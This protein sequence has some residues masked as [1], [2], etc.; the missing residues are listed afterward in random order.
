LEATASSFS[1]AR[2]EFEAAWNDPANTPFELPPVDVN[3]VLRERYSLGTPFRMTREML[4]DMEAKKAWDPLSFIPYVVSEG[5]SW[6]RQSLADGSEHFF[7]ASQ[8]AAWIA[9]GRGL[10]L[11][12]VFVSHAERRIFF[13]G[14]AEFR[15]ATGEPLSASDYQ[16]LFHVEHAAAGTEADPLNVW[17]IVFLTERNDPRF[18]EPFKRMVAAGL[19][20]GFI[21][22]YIARDLGVKLDRSAAPAAG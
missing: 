21:E 2:H 20:P 7:R 4:W 14:R 6:D 19:L 15:S 1:A 18:T 9:E 22:I 5:G 17:R 11:E 13:M 3:K 10:V 16:P 12:E 8:Q